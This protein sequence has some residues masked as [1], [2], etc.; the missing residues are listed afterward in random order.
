MLLGQV[1]IA[2]HSNSILGTLN[3]IPAGAPSPVH[4]LKLGAV[5]R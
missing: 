3:L 5:A 4:R 1:T 2:K